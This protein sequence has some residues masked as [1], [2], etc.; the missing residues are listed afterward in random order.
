[1]PITNHVSRLARA[2]TTAAAI[3]VTAC[4]SAPPPVSRPQ[5]LPLGREYAPSSA[6][7]ASPPPAATTSDVAPR[8]EEP[9]GQ[10]TLQRALSQ[11]LLGSPEL[12]AFS[13]DVRA[14]EARTM[15]A[16]FLPNPVLGLDSQDFGGRDTRSGFSGAQTTLSFSQL[17]E[18]GGKRAKRVRAAQLDESLAAWDYEAKRLDTLLETSRAFFG[19]LAA[20]QRLDLAQEALGLD[21]QVHG[22]VSERVRAG[23]VSP[24]EERRAQV[25]VANAT[26]AL[27]RARRDVEAARDRLVMQWGGRSA[28]FE[29]AVG[30]LA[31][32]TPP[33]SLPDVLSLAAR[34]PDVARWGHE[35]ESREAKLAV[36]RSKDIPDP[37]L[38]AGVRQYGEDNSKAFVAGISIPIPVF[39]LNQGNV[40]DAQHRL[41]K[42]YAERRAA[43]ARAANAARQGFQK[44][45]TAF[46]E[47]MSLKRDV[48]PAATT[49][50]DGA[51]EGY[52]LGK[53]SL[54]DVLDSQRALTE[55]RA[56]QVDAMAEYQG[57]RAELER[58]IGQPLTTVTQPD[59]LRRGDK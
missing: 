30:D 50:F 1:M 44:L 3:L 56:R 43:E 18:L 28:T 42:G 2:G 5:P 4:E 13:Y 8:T 38:S 22:S 34:N 26:L 37:T 51:S 20:Q 49:A 10:L 58:L 48:L 40:L 23:K 14:A 11:A 16:D 17:V 53:F 21:R 35:V 6:F 24:L 29:R 7:D 36:E 32:I 39:G 33:P 41:A 12:A 55:A 59:A 15:Q 54:T 46:D 9:V 52:G 31:D 27:E 25:A 45:S 47:V 57:A 19:L